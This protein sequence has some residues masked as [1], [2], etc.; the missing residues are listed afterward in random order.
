MNRIT[1]IIISSFILVLFSC[2]DNNGNGESVLPESGTIL[3]NVSFT[4]SWP[5]SGD[6]LITLDTAYPPQGPP[7]AFSYITSDELS[8]GIYGYRFSNLSF[9]SY[10]AITVTYWSLGYATAGTNYSL[11]GSF[12]DS[13]NVTQE[14]PELTIGIDATFE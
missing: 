12:I 7:A 2:E 3:G 9:R 6:V 14:E 8:E 1:K 4:G 5:D 11:I 10:E 13:I